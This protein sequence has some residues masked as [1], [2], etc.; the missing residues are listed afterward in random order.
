MPKGM[1]SIGIEIDSQSIRAAK[2]RP[3]KSVKGSSPVISSLEEITGSF[4]KDEEIIDG[5]KTLRQKMAISSTDIVVTCVGGKQ[6]Y[7][8]QLPFRKLPDEEMKTALKFEI[9]K[10]LSFDTS[11]ASIEYQFL[12]Q[13][14]KKSDSAPV[15]VTAVA[16]VLLQRYLRLFD[17]A[18]LP[19]SII[20]VFP[21]TVAN[22]LWA[23]KDI[24]EPADCGKILLHIGPDFSTVVIDGN[25]IPFYNRTI[26]FSAAELFGPAPGEPLAAREI[27]RRIAAFTEE[28]TRSL[29]YYESTYRTKT[30]TTVT[31]LG[32]YVVPE[33]IAKITQDTGLTV[34][35]LDLVN[36]F[37]A[38]QT[39]TAG[40]FDIAVSLGMRGWQ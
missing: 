13:P 5:L 35:Q 22:T 3:G 33:I 21:L 36:E 15:I 14:A 11:G 32:S 23:G 25:E 16:N 39:T 9:R 6:T 29:T 24:R 38:K 27:Q 10:N 30:A 34:N 7:A 19:P 26:Y 4:V 8:V 17:K 40:K 37:D 28:I 2:V 1:V 31:V 12:S 18:G 20:E